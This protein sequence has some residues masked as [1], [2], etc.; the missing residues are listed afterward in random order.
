MQTSKECPSSLQYDG[1]NL[2]FKNEKQ[3]DLNFHIKSNKD[4]LL[5]R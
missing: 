1:K 3:N 2:S 5:H 4:E